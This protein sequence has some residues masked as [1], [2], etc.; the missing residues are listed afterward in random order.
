MQRK[1]TLS[2]AWSSRRTQRNGDPCKTFT[3]IDVRA[4]RSATV[5][6][7]SKKGGVTQTLHHVQVSDV[8]D[9]TLQPHVACDSTLCF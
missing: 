9:V 5:A 6:D 8:S 2:N 3:L 4:A 7:P 1:R